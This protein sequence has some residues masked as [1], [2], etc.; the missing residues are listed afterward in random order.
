MQMLWGSN[1]RLTGLFFGI[2]L[3]HCIAVFMC[4]VSA[5]KYWSQQF[6]PWAVSCSQHSWISWG[7]PWCLQQYFPSEQWG[8]GM[9][10]PTP[11]LAWTWSWSFASVLGPLP[12]INKKR[13]VTAVHLLWWVKPNRGKQSWERCLHL[14][15]HC[16]LPA[17]VWRHQPGAAWSLL[18]HQIQRDTCTESLHH[19]D[20]ED[21][22]AHTNGSQRHHINK[23]DKVNCGTD[24]DSRLTD[25]YICF[26]IHVT[27]SFLMSI[28]SSNSWM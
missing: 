11:L 23:C 5:Q 12:S 16:I 22:E 1:C 18:G 2:L 27:Y 24:V 17:S 25:G 3:L 6:L 14:M 10:W 4:D 9:G 21:A 15:L 13:E 20:P 8:W 7:L 28:R 26:W 19:H